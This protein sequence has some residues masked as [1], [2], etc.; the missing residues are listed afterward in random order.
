MTSIPPIKLPTATRRIQ[1]CSGH[2]VAQHES[3]C[4]HLHGH[5]YV[6]LVTARMKPAVAQRLLLN[7]RN[8]PDPANS[9]LDEI[10]RVIDFSVLKERVGGWIETNWDHGFILW[11]KDNAAM[12]AM[13][14]AA[15]ALEYGQ[16][17][18]LMPYNP[19]AENMAR[20]LVTVVGPAVFGEAICPVEVC[21]VRIWE[22]ENCYADAQLV[23]HDLVAPSVEE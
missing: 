13:E 17:L 16:K 8:T 2:R 10:G 23:D 22:T 7:M 4:A 14:T 5:N 1:W 3:K 15:R 9:F 20:Y 21:H 18:H 11:D 6:A 12:R 19:T